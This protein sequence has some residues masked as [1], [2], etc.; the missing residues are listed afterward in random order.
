MF[1]SCGK[2]IKMVA[3]CKEQENHR[4]VV[5]FLTASGKQ[6]IH[7]L[8]YQTSSSSTRGHSLPGLTALG[9]RSDRD[10][11]D[12]ALLALVDVVDGGLLEPKLLLQF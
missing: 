10:G 7:H 2:Y 9:G 4:F 11:V 6:N 8:A 3:C 5:I 12:G 1:D